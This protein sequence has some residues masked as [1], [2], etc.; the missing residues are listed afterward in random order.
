L[1]STERG[2]KLRGE[3]LKWC[4]KKGDEEEEEETTAALVVSRKNKREMEAP[5]RRF[6]TFVLFSANEK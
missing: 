6:I 3:K 2:E 4:E 5:T 1:N